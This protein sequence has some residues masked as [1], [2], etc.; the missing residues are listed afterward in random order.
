MGMKNGGSSSWFRAAKP[1]DPACQWQNECLPSLKLLSLKLTWV[2][3]K[4]GVP[5]NGWFIIKTSIK[6]HDFGGTIIFGNTHIAPENWLLE[7]KP[8]LAHS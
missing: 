7:D 6:I 1:Q 8:F 3:P 5:Q 2:F 4:I